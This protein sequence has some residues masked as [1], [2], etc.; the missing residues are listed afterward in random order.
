MGSSSWELRI[1]WPYLCATMCLPIVHWE[2]KPEPCLRG[3]ILLSLSYIPQISLK[4][5]HFI[6][7]C[8]VNVPDVYEWPWEQKRIPVSRELELE[9]MQIWALEIGPKRSLGRAASTLNH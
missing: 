7:V 3:H 5:Y 6:C 2:L 8:S 9:P 4:R 1:F